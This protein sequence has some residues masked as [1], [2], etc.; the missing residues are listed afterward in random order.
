MDKTIEKFWYEV[1]GNLFFLNQNNIAQEI[2]LIFKINPFSKIC[3]SEYT[4]EV[5][6]N[7]TYST[8]SLT[9]KMDPG[10]L[11]Q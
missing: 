3:L 5:I 10:A 2:L 9:D 11:V 4:T 7:Y 8:Y 1:L 6:E